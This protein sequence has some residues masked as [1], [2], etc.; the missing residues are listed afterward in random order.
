M[1]QFTPNYL[2]RA[3]ILERMPRGW[4]ILGFAA[5][6]WGLLAGTMLGLSAL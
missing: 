4:V 2:S 1:Y 6:S 5:G 3:A